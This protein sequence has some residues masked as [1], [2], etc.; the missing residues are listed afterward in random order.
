MA[1][2]MDNIKSELFPVIKQNEFHA[3]NCEEHPHIIYKKLM[4][5]CRKYMDY[6][7]LQWWHSRWC[8]WAI[9]GPVSSPM[10]LCELSKQSSNTHEPK[11]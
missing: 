9:T 8:W 5:S 6:Q 1:Q 11:S 2:N 3:H 7:P 4:L 10:F